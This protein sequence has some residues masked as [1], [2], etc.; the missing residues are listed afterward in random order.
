MGYRMI[1]W[2]P[3]VAFERCIIMKALGRT[4][5]KVG[6][7]LQQRLTVSIACGKTYQEISEPIKEKHKV[8]SH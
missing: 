3:P 2:K 1:T 6:A 7:A 4:F 5:R 8:G